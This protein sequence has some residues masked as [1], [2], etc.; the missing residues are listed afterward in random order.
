MSEEWKE[1]FYN[2]FCVKL[3]NEEVIRDD[4]EPKQILEYFCTLLAEQAE[5]QGIIEKR[6]SVSRQI[7][8]LNQ[9]KAKILE[10]VGG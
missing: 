4:I 10:V 1:E 3:N 8:L 9:A 2:N 7:S 5:K 6:F